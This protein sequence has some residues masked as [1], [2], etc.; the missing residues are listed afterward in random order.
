MKCAQR[1]G[2][3]NRQASLRKQRDPGW[4]TEGLLPGARHKRAHDGG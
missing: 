2:V 3:V 4:Q 1:L